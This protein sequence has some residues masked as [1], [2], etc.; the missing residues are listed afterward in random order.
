[1]GTSTAGATFQLLDNNNI[2]LSGN[3]TG[4]TMTLQ[5]TANNG[6]II[7]GSSNLTGTANVT[8]NANGSGNITDTTGTISG[9]TI[10]LTSGMGNIGS[11]GNNLLTSASTL[12]ANT[13]G[14]GNVYLSQTG[15]LILNQSSSGGDFD[16]T[17]SNGSTLTLN[18]TYITAG[19]NMT[20][21]ATNGQILLDTVANP[22][23]LGANNITLVAGSGANAIWVRNGGTI[24]GGSDETFDAS[25]PIVTNTTY[26]AGGFIFNT[27]QAWNLTNDTFHILGITG[28]ITTTGD[29][30]GSTTNQWNAGTLAFNSDTSGS[31]NNGVVNTSTGSG[32]GI[33]FNNAASIT[34]TGMVVSGTNTTITFNN[35]TGNISMSGQYN[36][37]VCSGTVGSSTVITDTA[38][39]LN[40]GALSNA[41]GNM[42][43]QG[44]GIALQ[45]NMSANSLTLTATGS[46]SIT[47]TS[48]T[49]SA[50]TISI[51]T[52]SG[53]I[54]T[55]SSSILTSSTGTLTANTGG[56]GN[57]YVSNTGTVSLGTSV[58]GATFQL[59]DNNTITL[60]GNLTA[61]T[62][63]LQ[64]TAS[65]GCIAMGANNITGS[66]S[67]MLAANGT[68]NITDTTGAI[69]GGSISLNSGGGNIGGSSNN[70]LTATT[71][72]IAA[73]TGGSGNAYV[74]NTGAASL[75]TSTVGDTFQL[76]DNNTITTTGNISA[77]TLTL[78]TTANNGNITIGANNLSETSGLNLTSVN[79]I[80]VAA[81]ASITEASASVSGMTLTAVG[82][83]LF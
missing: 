17:T 8:L 83:I 53:N 60:A 42:T 14:S 66:S 26:T 78:Q 67:V 31:G 33:T 2:T 1:M 4:P 71:S 10:A 80:T 68:G 22:S 81:G 36:Q 55:N 82:S 16:I 57:A 61:P 39:I 62:I 34:G 11:N 70:I 44:V 52:S 19:G 50:P 29:V 40:L 18:G 59:V 41:S 76:L 79:N 30:Q 20:L 9:G 38:G 65:N 74:T 73:N 23:F 37:A 35:V 56:T 72:T 24:V 5:T 15:S 54:G 48:A 69:T 77:S 64:T 25:D 58:T 63:N 21:T 45:G 43:Y 7:E 49:M 6:N 32:G 27:G 13:G 51:T 28:N 75:G 47:D 46:G 12:T 3:V